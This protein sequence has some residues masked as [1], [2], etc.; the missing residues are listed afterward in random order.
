MEGSMTASLIIRSVL[1]VE[2]STSVQPESEV[3]TVYT[4]SAS[5]RTTRASPAAVTFAAYA[6]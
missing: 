3:V 2:G 5:S 6:V 1:S 4:V